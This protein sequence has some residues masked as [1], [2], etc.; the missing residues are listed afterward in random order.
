MENNLRKSLVT[1]ITNKIQDRA[2]GTNDTT[3]K[4]EILSELEMFEQ[5]SFSKHDEVEIGSV[6]K[7]ETNS[8][9]AQYFLTPAMS[10]EILEFQKAKILTV[11]IFST[12][13]MHL[14]GKKVGE[15]FNINAKEFEIKEIW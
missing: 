10:G 8:T 1:Q 3:S 11:S 12:L 13:G 7:L 15:K 5:I 2:L 6:V 9:Q 4:D 14:M